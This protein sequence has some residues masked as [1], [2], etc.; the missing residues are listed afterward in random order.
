M[1]KVN[2]GRTH[3][4]QRVI[5]IVHFSLRL[6]C[7]KN[8]IN[9]VKDI[10]SCFLSSSVSLNSVQRFQKRSRKCLSQSDAKAASCFS[11]KNT[12]LVDDGEILLPVKFR[13]IPFSAFKEV[14]NVKVN[15]GWWTDRQRTDGRRAMT[16]AQF[17][18]RL[19]CTK[20]SNEFYRLDWQKSRVRISWTM[21][22]IRRPILVYI[23]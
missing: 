21:C 20:N 13:W 10:R 22:P 4:G 19:R 1:W 7:T 12:N 6:R 8:N 17:S 15:A 16:I 3:D 18:L 14:K 23:H 2:D 9:L 5:T 11:A